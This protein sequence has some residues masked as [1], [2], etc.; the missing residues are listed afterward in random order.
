MGYCLGAMT[1]ELMA[2]LHIEEFG[3][4]GPKNYAYR[5]VKP[6]TGERDTVCKV[7]VITLKF[8]DSKLLN[9]DAMRDII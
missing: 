7:R 9:F 8:S 1:S 2:G 4:G 3:S 5:T 6:T